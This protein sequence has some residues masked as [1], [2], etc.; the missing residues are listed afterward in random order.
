VSVVLKSLIAL[1]PAS[2]L[3]VASA[4]IFIREKRLS[5]ALQLVGTSGVVI[6]VFAHLCEAFHL[7]P[8]MHWGEE[9]SAGHYL[10]L[11]GA[12]VGLTLFP[13]GFLLSAL[14]LRRH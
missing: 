8:W 9:H 12:V 10:D 14:T 13:L 11:F 3:L 4:I 5:S 1:V 6:V 7:F 2:V